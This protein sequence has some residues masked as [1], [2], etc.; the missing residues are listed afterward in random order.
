MLFRAPPHMALEWDESGIQGMRRWLQR[1]W[2]LVA[3]NEETDAG[4]RGGEEHDLKRA[5]YEAVL[6]VTGDLEQRYAF[7]TAIAAL[8]SLSNSLR[9]SNRRTAAH[10]N[11][12]RD[13]L[14]IMLAPLAPHIADEAWITLHGKSVFSE[15][16]P[17]VSNE[18]SS[19]K[20]QQQAE[21]V[22]VSVLVNG[23]KRASIEMESEWL[24]TANNDAILKCVRAS[25]VGEKWLAVGGDVSQVIVVAKQNLVNLVV[26]AN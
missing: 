3:A 8:M 21:R 18:T 1:L 5:T 23:K 25:P 13:A 4:G 6:Q 15:A 9:R 7:N 19:G 12:A 2:Q 20:Q 24:A 10:W 26:K 16:W 14:F 17:T 22:S 11:E